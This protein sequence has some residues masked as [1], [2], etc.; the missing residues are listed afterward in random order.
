MT[1]PA[2]INECHH[3]R[4]CHGAQHIEINIFT[5]PIAHPTMNSFDPD[6]LIT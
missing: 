1:K 5:L 3:C 4:F 6:W 2:I